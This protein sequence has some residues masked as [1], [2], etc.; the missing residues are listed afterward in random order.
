MSVPPPHSPP[1]ASTIS[2]T[3][4]RRAVDDRMLVGVCGGL[5]KAFAVPALAVRLGAIAIAIPA[6]P[7]V[8]TTYAVLA[9]VVPRED[10]RTL[11]GGTPNDARENVIGWGVVALAAAVLLATGI[12]GTDGPTF[13]PAMIFFAIV[14]ALGVAAISTRRDAG[15]LPGVRAAPPTWT[16][17]A[18]AATGA[19]ASS[20]PTEP[21]PPRPVPLGDDPG[22]LNFVQ[23]PRSTIQVPFTTPPPPRRPRLPG[24]SLMLIGFAGIVLTTSI[25]SALLAGGFIDP[26][27][28]AAAVLFGTG[29]ALAAGGAIA[30]SGRRHAPGLLVL[31]VFLAA[32]AVG[33][34]TV[35]D[36]LDEGVGSR[37]YR[38]AT[39]A[40]L[41]PEYKL[42]AGEL[43]IDLR[44]TKLPPGDTVVRA[45]LG[46]GL[47]TVWVPE[48]VRVRDLGTT[49]VN[50]IDRT[51]RLAAR[52]EKRTKKTEPRRTVVIDADVALGDAEVW[53]GDDT[54]RRW[55]D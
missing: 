48:G 39:A 2:H 54:P 38:P 40:A 5:A 43:V 45:D 25:V 24:P 6:A 37:T 29:A 8:L 36:E 1:S 34:A 30:F 53:V 18:T 28:S 46:A 41:S 22:P 16:A 13:D 21:L 17:A 42:G 49:S 35:G 10:G 19:P 27:A 47:V 15:A 44:D 52:A 12:D 33:T 32:A 23:P 11:L 9:V 31:G 4:I 14:A 51:N 7:F 3:T 50:N 55:D 26:S 20:A